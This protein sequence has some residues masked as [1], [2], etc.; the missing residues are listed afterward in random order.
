MLKVD[1]QA[2]I[3]ALYYG[4]K[5]SVRAI[6]EKL[7]INRKSV[8]AVVAR[9][10]VALAPIKTDRGSILDPFK[11][12]I[13]ELLRSDP[14]IAATTVHARIR[15]HG[16]M[17][18]VTIVRAYIAKKRKVPHKN[19][20]AFLRLEF[21]AGQCAQVDWGEFGDPFGNGVKIHCFV[22]VLCYSRLIYVEFTRS[23]R[24]EEFIR[25]HENAFKFFGS[26]VPLE[27]WYDN[28]ATA[29]TERMGSLVRFNSRF[30]TY[31]AHHTIRPHACNPARGNEKGSVEDG[32]KY[33]RSSFWAG[34]KFTD[35][36]SL[37]QQAMLWRD[38]IAN[39]REHRVTRK[40]PILLFEAEE[41]MAMREMNPHSFDTAEVF[42]KVVGP[43][44]HIPYETNF[45][46]VPWTLV[47]MSITVRVT[48]KEIEIYYRDQ[49]VSRH[50]RS[51]KKHQHITMVEHSR[52]LLE[53]KPG[54]SSDRWQMSAIKSIG[55]HM[56]KYLSLIESGSRSLRNE[57]SQILALATVFGEQEV[58]LCA[59]E[60]LDSS[61]VGVEHLE[62]LL[63]ARR[64][65]NQEH[66]LAPKPIQFQN[67]KLNRVVPSV[68]LRRFDALLFESKKDEE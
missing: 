37:T 64:F 23:E 42:T 14:F 57:L 65:Q 5:K 16:F 18:G 40:I 2:E 52:G 47:G 39:K 32:V 38:N 13:E 26:R 44:F 30:F 29:V 12:Q 27:C 31:M 46:S 66:E 41:K 17:G 10:N 34:R 9:K 15:A 22:M 33:I 11:E 63:K 4:D 28:L 1:I 35:F 59:K 60:L 43:Q 54:G 36:E 20:E 51:Y 62:R 55:P 45:Y 19:R 25:C 56:E 3:L 21:A 24:F 61:I 50:V 7:G 68:D 6:A 67:S 8:A 48:A 58:N 49:P 53:R